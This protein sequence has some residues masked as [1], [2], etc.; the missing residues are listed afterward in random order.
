MAS[1][2]AASGT[3]EFYVMSARKKINWK[4]MQKMIGNRNLNWREDDD[5]DDICVYNGT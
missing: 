2:N 3:A 4:T 1:W 5:I